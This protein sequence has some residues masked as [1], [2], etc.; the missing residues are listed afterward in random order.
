MNRK[1]IDLSQIDLE[2]LVRMIEEG[3]IDCKL[4][5]IDVNDPEK[6]PVKVEVYVD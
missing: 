2:E 1:G 3:L 4:V 6:G 5:D